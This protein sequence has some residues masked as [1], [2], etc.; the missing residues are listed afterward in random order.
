MFGIGVF[1]YLIIGAM[2]FAIPTLLVVIIGKG[3]RQGLGGGEEIEMIQEIHRGL[4][5][6]E[7]RVESLETLLLER[8]V[9]K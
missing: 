8:R 5:R 4:E 1:E 9:E 6:M 7:K 2:I 3:V